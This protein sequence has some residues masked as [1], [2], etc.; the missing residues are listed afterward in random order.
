MKGI[1]LACVG[2]VLVGGGLGGVL[3][4]YTGNVEDIPKWNG[5]Y[6]FVFGIKEG[7]F[8]SIPLAVVFFFLLLIFRFFYKCFFSNKGKVP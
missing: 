5:L 1:L 8:F 4:L 3:S 7:L 6:Y 2:I